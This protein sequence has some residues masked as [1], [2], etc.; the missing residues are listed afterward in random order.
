MYREEEPAESKAD[1]E[2]RERIMRW[3]REGKPLSMIADKLGVSLA[4]V[5]EMC[6]ISLVT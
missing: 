3:F 2:R 1:T 6:K 5:R 4:E